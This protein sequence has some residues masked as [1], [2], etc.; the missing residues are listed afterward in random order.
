MKSGCLCY[1]ETVYVIPGNYQYSSNPFYQECE[2][3][4][5][6]NFNCS[7]ATNY[8]VNQFV[9]DGGTTLRNVTFNV[10]GARPISLSLEILWVN[11]YP[12]HLDLSL[13]S[14]TALTDNISHVS[15]PLLVSLKF[16]VRYFLTIIIINIFSILDRTH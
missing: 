16:G 11:H 1:A 7:K 12:V 10:L 5:V 4:I 2:Q 15:S 3:K 13:S 6:N 14:D 9:R 8:P